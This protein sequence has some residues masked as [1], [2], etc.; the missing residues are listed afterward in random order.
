MFFIYNSKVE[1]GFENDV[2]WSHPVLSV[3]GRL[4]VIRSYML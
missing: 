3:N 2:E 4:R 1:D